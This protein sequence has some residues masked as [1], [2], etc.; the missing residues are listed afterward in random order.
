M[1]D[2]CFIMKIK[3]KCFYC[4]HYITD[5][6]IFIIQ[7]EYYFIDDGPYLDSL[8]AVVEHYTLMPDGLPTTLQRPVPPMPAP[9]V[10][11]NPRPSLLNGVRLKTIK[12]N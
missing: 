3:K 5:I 4:Q 1:D 11:D 7:G 12:T 8:E 9:P 2:F 10:P 6:F